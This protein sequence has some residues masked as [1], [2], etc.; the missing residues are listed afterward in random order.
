MRITVTFAE[1]EG[2][3]RVTA[4]HVGLEADQG[5]VQGWSE[6]LARLEEYLA[7]APTR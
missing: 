6:G 3:T 7:S 1:H 5:E 4:R 2:G